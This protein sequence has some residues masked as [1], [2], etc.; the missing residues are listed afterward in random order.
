MPEEKQKDSRIKSFFKRAAGFAIG[1]IAS[2]VVGAYLYL[3]SDSMTVTA[4]D[5]IEI[6]TTS[7]FKKGLVQGSATGIGAIFGLIVGGSIGVAM[8]AVAGFVGGT[9]AININKKTNSQANSQ[10]KP[11]STSHKQNEQEMTTL[12]KQRTKTPASPSYP[13]LFNSSLSVSSQHLATPRSTRE[14]KSNTRK[15]SI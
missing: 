3:T 11:T 7:S 13:K 9:C 4:G 14:T 1:I 6:D 8:G 15:T 2:P 12:Q 5:S 10:A